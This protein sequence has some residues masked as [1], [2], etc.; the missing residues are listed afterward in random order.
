MINLSKK[1]KREKILKNIRKLYFIIDQVTQSIKQKKKHLNL[2]EEDE[3][4]RRRR[5]KKERKQIILFVSK[6]INKWRKKQKKQKQKYF[7][8]TLR[9]L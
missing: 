2:D 3:K 5:R 1:R 4:K 9:C 8:L 6:I 7:S